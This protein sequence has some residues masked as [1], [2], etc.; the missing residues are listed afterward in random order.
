[1]IGIYKITNK[2]NGKSYIGQSINIVQRW[3]QHRTNAMVRT[4]AL[5]LAFQKYGIENF[6][7]EVLEE[8]S[9]EELDQREQ[10]YISF[11]NSY[12]NGYNM[13]QGRQNNKEF[14]SSEIFKLWTMEKQYLKLAPH[15]EYQEVLYIVDLINILIIVKKSLINVTVK[16]L[17]RR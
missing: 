17:I 11:F 9:E 1:M 6:S 5:Y 8:C 4:E 16:K 3:K 14:Y 13:T 10:Y 15:Q 2:I 12:E 7:F